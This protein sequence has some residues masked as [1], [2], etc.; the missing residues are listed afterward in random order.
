MA[1]AL[2]VVIALID[3]TSWPALNPSYA[4]P[5]PFLVI[6]GSVLSIHAGWRLWRGHGHAAGEVA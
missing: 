3:A 6:L 4:A 2:M 5:V 1:L